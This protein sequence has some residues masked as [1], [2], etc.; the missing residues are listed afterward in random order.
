[1]IETTRSRAGRAAGTVPLGRPRPSAIRTQTGARAA[2]GAVP[3]KPRWVR[4]GQHQASVSRSDYVPV[5]KSR[6]KKP[7]RRRNLRQPASAGLAS[8]SSAPVGQNPRRASSPSGAAHLRATAAAVRSCRRRPLLP[9]GHLDGGSQHQGVETKPAIEGGRCRRPTTRRNARP[10]KILCTSLRGRIRLLRFVLYQ[11]PGVEP[12]PLPPVRHALPARIRARFSLFQYREGGFV[13][14][15]VIDSLGA[16]HNDT[17][18]V[19]SGCVT[20]RAAH[21][22]ACHLNAIPVPLSSY[23]NGPN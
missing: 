23:P 13:K 3:A 8:V 17:S 16:I 20:L 12:R 18:M 2:A 7:H 1:M 14:P 10:L 21:C 5:K 4:S 11:Q 22:M 9:V 19:T 6:N 15:Q